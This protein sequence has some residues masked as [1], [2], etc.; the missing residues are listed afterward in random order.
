MDCRRQSV[1]LTEIGRALEEPIALAKT[2]TR[3]SRTWAGR[4]SA[5]RWPSDPG[6]RQS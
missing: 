4:S 5:T 1:R 2:E 3:L 6:R